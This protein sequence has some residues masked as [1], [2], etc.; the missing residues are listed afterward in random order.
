MNIE[1]F[2]Q[3]SF[4][5]S[6]KIVQTRYRP[7]GYRLNFDVSCWA[8][9]T[10]PPPVGNPAGSD[11]CPVSVWAGTRPLPRHHVWSPHTLE[12]APPGA[13]SL[14]ASWGSCERPTH[15]PTAPRD[16]A[17]MFHW[18][19]RER[20]RLFRITSTWRSERCE[21]G[22]GGRTLTTVFY[23]RQ[24]WSLPPQ[25]PQKLLRVLLLFDVNLLIHTR[26]PRH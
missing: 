25:L 5:G 19:L 1:Y 3:L 11:L 6:N 18:S 21:G 16:R 17:D 14:P 4:S 15:C 8:P 13:P 2:W 12:F 9:W 24:G 26:D 10:H 20:R 23:I 7:S 22:R